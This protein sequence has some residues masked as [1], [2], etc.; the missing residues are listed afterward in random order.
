M[1]LSAHG[2]L[3]GHAECAQALL[4]AGAKPDHVHTREAIFIAP[5]D[6]GGHAECVQALM[7]AGAMFYQSFPLLMALPRRPRGVRCRRSWRLEHERLASAP[8]TIELSMHMRVYYLLSFMS[9]MSCYMRVRKH[10]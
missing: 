6:L 4:T 2:R 1:G 5:A 9:L 8:H 7:E 10:G 3:D